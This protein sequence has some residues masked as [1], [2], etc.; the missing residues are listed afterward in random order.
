MWSTGA[1]QADRLG[2]FAKTKLPFLF[3]QKRLQKDRGKNY[4]EI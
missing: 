3:L 4:D 2:S 1:Y